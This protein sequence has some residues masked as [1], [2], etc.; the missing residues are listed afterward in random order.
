M[1]APQVG[2]LASRIKLVIIIAGAVAALAVL[3]TLALVVVLPP[4]ISVSPGDGSS[5][6][7]PDDSE[8]EISTSRWG[9]SLA[10]VAVKEAKIA[11]DGTRESERLLSG[12]LTDGR[13]VLE[14]GS[15]PLVADAE[16]TITVSGTVKEFGISGVTD[17]PVEQT[18]TF[19][20]VTTPMPITPKDGLKVKYGED[21][22]LEWNIPIS[23]F[24]YSLEGIQSTSRLEDGGRVAHISLAKFEQGQAYPLKVTGATS[25][26][27]RELKAPVVST[28]TTAPPLQ[29]VFEP[30]D[31]TSGVSTEAAPAIVFSEPVSNQD[32]ARTLVSVEPKVDGTFSWPAPNR[33]EFK[34]TAAWDH[35]QDVTITLKGGPAGVRG[36]SGGFIE[37]DSAATF[38]TAPAK[39]IDV[40]ISEQRVTLYENGVAVDSFLCS[41]GN[42]GTDTPM[43]DYTIYAKMPAIDMRGPGYFAPKVPWVMVF[44]GDYTMHGNYWATAFGQRSS[45]G[46]VGLPVDTAKRVY[47][48]TPI[49]TSIHIHE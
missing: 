7:M 12:H 34:P 44:K 23:D 9:A 6:I 28:V 43:G 2:K 36:V 27:G 39:S 45:H 41:T 21:V 5:E 15:S 32:L 48:W 14:D 13:F 46:C 42:S 10:T 11:P 25:S 24:E 40:S 19:T 8:L 37:A 38:T 1:T 31:G 16:Y 18:L 33:L 47:D 20:T 26:N 49:G 17:T 22:I 29:P 3:A 30:A 35:L 4:R